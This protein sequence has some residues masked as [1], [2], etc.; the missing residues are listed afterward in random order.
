MSTILWILLA[1][2]YLAALVWLGFRTLSN[3]HT[4][5][6]FFGLFLPV[7]WIPGALMAPTH[8]EAASRARANLR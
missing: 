2:A 3:G 6:F 8:A 7:L 5:L 1:L 4:L